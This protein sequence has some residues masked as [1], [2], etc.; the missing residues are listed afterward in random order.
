VELEGAA[1][2][3]STDPTVVGHSLVDVPDLNALNDEYHSVKLYPCFPDNLLPHANCS[4]ARLLQPNRRSARPCKGTLRGVPAMC[5]EPDR[6]SV[7]I[8]S[9]DLQSSYDCACVRDACSRYTRGLGPMMSNST[10]HVNG[11]EQRKRGEIQAS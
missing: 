8:A 3:R 6:S 7:T 11:Q 1:G 2:A 5:R 10:L 9:R 4:Y